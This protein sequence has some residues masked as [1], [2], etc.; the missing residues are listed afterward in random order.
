MIIQP[1]DIVN[2]LENKKVKLVIN[3]NWWDYISFK[4]NGIN[5]SNTLYYGYTEFGSTSTC[6]PLEVVNLIIKHFVNKDVLNCSVW[7]EEPGFVQ[8]S[9]INNN[10]YLKHYTDEAWSENYENKNYCDIKF[11]KENSEEALIEFID[12][13]NIIYEDIV[14]QYEN[15]KEKVDMPEELEMIDK[16]LKVYK[17]I[18]KSIK[19]KLTYEEEKEINEYSKSLNLNI[20]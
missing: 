7:G 11:I 12:F 16:S 15:Y 5:D 10:I 9:L 14:S 18:I 19:E 6:F 8:I 4:T 2:E 3:K 20:I 13:I 17:L 1:K